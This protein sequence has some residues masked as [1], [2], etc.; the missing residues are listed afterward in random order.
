LACGHCLYS[1]RGVAPDFVG[2]AKYFKLAADPDQSEAQMCYGVCLHAGICV[3]G[4]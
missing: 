4:I 3:P 2:A 1:G